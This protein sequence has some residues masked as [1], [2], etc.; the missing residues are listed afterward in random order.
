MADQLLKIETTEAPKAVGPYSQGVSIKATQRIIFV[1]GQIPIEPKSGKLI[2]G[3]IKALTHQVLD[4]IE[5]I[6]VKAE[7]QHAANCTADVFA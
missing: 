3:D 7:Q 2:E 1:S 5:A 4:N 6:L